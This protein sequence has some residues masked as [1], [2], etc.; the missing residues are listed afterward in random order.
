VRHD[1]WLRLRAAESDAVH[2]PD[3]DI[4]PFALLRLVDDVVDV[5]SWQLWLALVA[6]IALLTEY[7]VVGSVYAAYAFTRRARAELGITR[8][9]MA[10]VV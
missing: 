5:P 6:L 7:L 8:R 9:R 4:V 2:D 10:A 1:G 3:P